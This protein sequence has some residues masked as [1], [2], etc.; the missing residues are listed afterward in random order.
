MNQLKAIVLTGMTLGLL[1]S[2]G[3]TKSAESITMKN[4]QFAALKELVAT[5]SFVVAVES[6]YPLQTYAVMQV[7]NALLQNTGNT[8]SRIPLIG[9]GDYIKIKGDTVQA[10]LA[11][12]GEVRMV[13]SL[14]PRDSG[15]NFEGVP[16][17]FDVTENEKKQTIKLEFEIK[18]KSDLFSVIMQLY[19]NKRAIVFI[20][21]M[22]RTSIRYEGKLNAFEE[23]ETSSRK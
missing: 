14:N 13:S 10:E 18:S 4:Q 5:K 17:T 16:S 2:C 12:Y 20:N 19:A 22:T 3:S 21:S 11:Y 15:I 8:G 1:W 6:A 9:N 7:T 23:P